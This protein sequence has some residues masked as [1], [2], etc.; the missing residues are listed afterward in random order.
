MLS[1]SRIPLFVSL[2]A[3]SPAV[4]AQDANGSETFAPCADAGTHASLAGTQCARIEAPLDHDAAGGETIE[5]FVRRFPAEGAAKGELWLVAGGPGESGASFYPFIDTL[6]GGA[7]G[8]DLVIPDHRGTGFSTRLC[9]IEESPESAGGTAIEGAEWGTCFRAL[10]AVPDRTRAFS[11]TNA[12]HDL[13]MLM[14]RL[15]DGRPRYLY[16]VSYGTQ[17][18]LRT[19]AVAGKDVAD[20]VILDSLVP[21][22]ATEEFDLSRRS[23]VVDMVGR[24]VLAECD[25]LADC[26]RYF[27]GP[28]ADTLSQVLADPDLAEPL[29]PKPKYTLGAFLD[30]PET[31]AMLPYVIAGLKA[32]DARWLE[33]AEARLAELSGIFAPYPQAASSIP[34]VSVISRSE[35]NPRPELT[36]ETIAEEEAGLLFASPLPSLLLMGGIPAY[37]KDD[38]FAAPP[39]ALPPTLV[40]H[41]TLDPK[42]T[43]AGA[44]QHVAMFEAAGDVELIEIDRAP[45]FILMVAPDE[46]AARLNS[47]IEATS[48]D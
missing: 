3:A 5:L 1:L 41:G 13:T 35:N 18:V 6:R 36:A 37:E 17:L 12:A 9:P 43:L 4:A 32:G 11:I 48:T 24:Q 40:M 30:L 42:T 29:G 7:P 14:D 25:A 34:L 39:K 8:Y 22:E 26:S 33:H 21:P 2:V 28:A 19:L 44:K 38:L 31:R 23:A 27:A 45:H 46:F 47:F 16:G 15:D 10:N 20:G